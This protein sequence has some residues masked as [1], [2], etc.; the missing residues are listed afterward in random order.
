MIRVTVLL[1]FKMFIALIFD[2][3]LIVLYNTD[4]L[5]KGM[6]FSD[7]A[8]M[9]RKKKQA[10]NSNKAFNKGLRSKR[11]SVILSDSTHVLDN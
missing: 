6:R 9:I 8:G 1:N 11:N 7:E 3:I 2:F 10:T 4:P 5:S